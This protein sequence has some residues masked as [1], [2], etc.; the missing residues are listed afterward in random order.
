MSA[1]LWVARI[2]IAFV[3]I[4]AAYG[5]WYLFFNNGAREH[6][7]AVLSASPSLLP[8]TVEPVKTVYTGIKAVDDQITLL[9]VVFWEAV[10]G[11]MPD[12]S[13]FCFSFGGQFAGTYILMLVESARQGN[14]GRLISL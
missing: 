2:L 12:L 10:D 13:L 11:S 3:W 7:H 5:T 14:R 9:A 4:Y 6:V 8:G 1:N